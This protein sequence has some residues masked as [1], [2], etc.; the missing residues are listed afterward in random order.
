MLARE[1]IIKD[2][3]DYMILNDVDILEELAYGNFAVLYDLVKIG[4]SCSDEEADTIIT[5]SL[6]KYGF[7][8]T[9]EMMALEVIGRE[10]SSDPSNNYDVKNKSYREVLED[11]YNQIQS[12]DKNLSLTDFWHISTRYMYKYADGLK[13]RFI[14]NLNKQSQESFLNAETF[15]GLLFGKLKEPLHFNKDGKV[16][17]HAEEEMSLKDKILAVKNHQY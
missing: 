11:F 12:I 7:D 6:D 5:K 16:Q 9:F 15:I 10:P 2:L 13:D 8:K 17:R 3:I 1:F 14:L 4:N